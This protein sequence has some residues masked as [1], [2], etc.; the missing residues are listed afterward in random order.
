MRDKPLPD[1]S[2][3]RLHTDADEKINAGCIKCRVRHMA[4]H[5][6]DGTAVVHGSVSVAPSNR[7]ARRWTPARRCVEILL[8]G[9]ALF[10]LGIL[11]G[12]DPAKGAESYAIAMHGAPAL[13]ATFSHLPSTNA[14]APKG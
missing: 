5:R 8:C 1:W 4:F 7:C 12:R 14:N 3:G 9:L 6:E 13:P 11:T 10:N 2:I